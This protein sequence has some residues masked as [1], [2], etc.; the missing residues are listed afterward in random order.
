MR[1]EVS[2]TCYLSA[3][4]G[5]RGAVC[6]GPQIARGPLAAP[7]CLGM[8]TPLEQGFGGRVAKRERTRGR[9]RVYSSIRACWCG[10]RQ[11]TS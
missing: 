6:S 10:M 7:Q 9:E 4:V 1:A 11:R 3:D 2:V 5:L 8:M